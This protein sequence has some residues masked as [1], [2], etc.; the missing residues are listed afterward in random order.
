MALAGQP[1][2]LVTN[3]VIERFTA[4]LN[5]CAQSA[6]KEPRTAKNWHALWVVGSILADA[7]EI[8]NLSRHTYATDLG[9]C[10]RVH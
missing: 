6:D 2:A 10:R 4:G 3:A 9:P 8:L 5:F 7:G 1:Q